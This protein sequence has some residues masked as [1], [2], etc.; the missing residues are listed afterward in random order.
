MGRDEVTSVLLDTHVLTWLVGKSPKLGK[1]ALRTIDR[2]TSR[3]GALMSAITPWEVSMG[4]ER[5]RISIEKGVEQWVA[6]ALA[7]PGIRLAPL[8]PEIAIAAARLPRSFMNDPADQII[9]AT[10]RYLGIPLVTADHKIL[11]YGRAGHVRVVDA[12]D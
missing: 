10:A 12:T 5:G 3:D 1:K 9:V 4:V 8:E 11:D 2:A 7:M 6:E